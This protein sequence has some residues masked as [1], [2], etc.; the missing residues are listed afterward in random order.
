MKIKIIAENFLLYQFFQIRVQGWLRKWNNNVLLIGMDS[1]PLHKP[2]GFTG[3]RSGHT[4]KNN[5]KTSHTNF[6]PA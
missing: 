6:S 4:V 2:I 3:V 1:L 5:E